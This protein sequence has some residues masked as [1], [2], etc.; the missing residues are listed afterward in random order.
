MLIYDE[1]TWVSEGPLWI[2]Q[3]L[4][5]LGMLMQRLI[6][7]LICFPLMVFAEGE[8]GIKFDKELT[9]PEVL[10]KARVENKYIFIDCYTTYCGWCKKMGEETFT[11]EKVGKAFNEKFIS[12]KLQI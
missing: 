6:Y 5:I 12:V 8:T 9:W 11:Q 10:A 4:R 3:L 1:F 2:H 7:F